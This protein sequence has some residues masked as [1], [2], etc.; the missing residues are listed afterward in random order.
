[1]VLVILEAPDF[2]D[3]FEVAQQ[4]DT[5]E[6]WKAFVKIYPDGFFA[7]LALSELQKHTS[8]HD[9]SGAKK[10][11]KSHNSLR[12]SVGRIANM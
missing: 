8:M 10:K 7:E 9:D 2:F 1:M 12:G 5:E 6:G 4:L 11:P 3:A